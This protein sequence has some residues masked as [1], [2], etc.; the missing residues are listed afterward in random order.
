MIL[1]T[2]FFIDLLRNYPPAIR[3]A[4][5]LI[6]QGTPLLTTTVTV[7][8]L[9][10]GY[11]TLEHKKIEK[12][13]EMLDQLLI[14]PLDVPSAKT[15]GRISRTLLE[16]GQMIEP[17]DTLIAGITLEKNEILLTQNTNHFQR[18]PNLKLETY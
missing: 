8:E 2:T 5:S 15:A 17:E 4:Q 16:K 10:R 6:L 7:F 3:K 11:G 18:I 1:D 14:Y 9:W 12:A 13:A